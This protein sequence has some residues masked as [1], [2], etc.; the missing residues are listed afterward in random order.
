[1]QSGDFV[2]LVWWMPYDEEGNC[3]PGFDFEDCSLIGT[4]STRER[5]EASIARAR[6]LPGFS[7]H[8][9]GFVIDA[10]ALDEDHWT[11]GFKTERTEE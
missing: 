2:Y 7:D 1:M 6:T 3:L 4:Y 8:P 11:S 10:Y 5:A 9:E